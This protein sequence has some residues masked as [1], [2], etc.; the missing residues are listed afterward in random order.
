MAAKP[1]LRCLDMCAWLFFTLPE[2]VLYIHV[3]EGTAPLLTLDRQQTILSLFFRAL[4]EPDHTSMVP[5][6]ELHL[7][8]GRSFLAR[9]R[10]QGLPDHFS[11][12]PSTLVGRLVLV[13]NLLFSHRAVVH[14]IV[15]S[16]SQ[17]NLHAIL[18]EELQAESK[19]WINTPEDITAK[20]TDDIWEVP[21]NNSAGGQIGMPDEHLWRFSAD[22]GLYNQEEE[23][24]LSSFLLSFIG[25]KQ[26][27][28]VCFFSCLLFL[29]KSVKCARAY[30]PVLKNC[31]VQLDITALHR[32]TCLPLRRSLRLSG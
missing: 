26:E 22:V 21:G 28:K 25:E 13:R 10:P 17:N 32:W 27:E 15:C 6:G 2:T 11:T 16:A 19:H 1:R 30:K 8:V 18:L 31:P 24:C 12:L 5:R 3:N 7:C 23:V 4:I 9:A 20:I 29:A 14:L